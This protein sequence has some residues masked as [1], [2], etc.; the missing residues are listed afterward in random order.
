MNSLAYKVI[1]A[2]GTAKD[3]VGEVTNPLPNAYKDVVGGGLTTFI[4]NIIRLAFVGAG[5]YALFNFIIAGYQYM[6]A[7]GDSKA[8][9]AAWDRIWQT[10]LG[11]VLLVGSF[12]LAALI[13]FIVFGDATF[14]LRPQIWGP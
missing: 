6:T 7:G 14:I 8:L 2:A 11:L 13:G 12:A 9:A 5:L 1:A 4:T 10:L 3:I